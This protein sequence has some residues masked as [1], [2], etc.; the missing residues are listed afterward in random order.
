M[1]YAGHTVGARAAPGLTGTRL[2]PRAKPAHRRPRTSPG[3]DAAEQG[4][5][6]S[7]RGCGRAGAGPVPAQTWATCL[8]IALRRRLGAPAR[9][10]RSERLQPLPHASNGQGSA[11][12]TEP[13]VATARRVARLHRHVVHEHAPVERPCCCAALDL[14]D[15]HAAHARI[16]P[17]MVRRESHHAAWDT[18]R[19][20]ALRAV[21]C[22]ATPRRC[23]GACRHGR[24]IG[25]PSPSPR[26]PPRR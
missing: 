1:A 20:R 18:V 10:G 21:P 9:E 4:R 19:W 11:A 8:R 5:A 15:L 6:Q 13:I 22:C 25:A 3:T 23:P 16:P 17:G 7:R 14:G 12:K 2:D 26:R 24:R